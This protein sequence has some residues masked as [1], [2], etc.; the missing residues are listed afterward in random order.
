MPAGSIDLWLVDLQASAPALEALERDT[1]RLSPEDHARA[2]TFPDAATRLAAYTA[3]RFVIERTAG[4]SVRGQP[5]TRNRAGKPQLDGS[6]V[7]FSLAHTD[8]F[9]LIAVTRQDAVGVDLEQARRINMADDHKQAIRAAGAGLAH[10]PLPAVG[11][12][13]AF[14]HAWARLEAFTKARG[15]T[16][17][18]TLEE[19][20][21]RGANRSASVAHIQAAAQQ[22]AHRSRLSVA[23][24]LLPPALYG[25]IAAPRLPAHIRAPLLP[26]D[27]AGLQALL[28]TR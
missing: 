2:A 15:V 26:A 8:A 17:P 19:T 9:A 20:A 4:A 12:D 18:R 1:P 21:V 22:L 6:G 27:R 10:A 7:A 3:L 11:L 14:L 5:F 23:D 28:D 25:A 13:R 24:V 16:L